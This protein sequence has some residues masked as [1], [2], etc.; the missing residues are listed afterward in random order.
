VFVVSLYHNK[1][2]LI[3]LPVAVI[4]LTVI[5]FIWA[6][7]H[8]MPPARLSITTAGVT[9]SYHSLGLRY[10][11]R[12]SAYGITLDVSASEGSQQ[13]MERLRAEQ[14]PSDLA[15]LQGGFGY[16]GTS[17]ERRERSK[18]ETLV[19]VRIEGAWLFT[20]A[21]TLTSL[22]QLKGLR[23]SAGQLG[24]GSRRVALKLLEQAQIDLKD[25]TL[26]DETGPLS[27][28]ALEQGLVDAVFFVAPDDSTTLKSLLAVPNIR[29]A[30]LSK[31]AA[32]TGRNPY[33]EPRL[34]AQGG[35][36]AGLPQQD[37]TL[38]TTTAS[39]VAREE[40]H[41]ALKRLAIAISTE[42][43]TTAGLFHRAEDFPSLR[44]LDFPS[45]PE[46]RSTLSQGLPFLE[47][48]LPFWWAQVVQ[49]LLLI[50]LP[51]LLLAWWLMRFIPLLLRWTLETRL[52]RWYGELKF[53]E[54]DLLKE[55]VP[56]LDLARF[57]VRLTAIEKELTDFRC[58][59]DLMARC[60][61]LR[62][63]TEFVRLQLY[64]VRGR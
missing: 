2:L 44:R 5:V 9:G 4:A 60:Y 32:I 42:V 54:N 43:H 27:V 47:R 31:S 26:S 58:P 6:V 57:S 62:Q 24:S 56:G 34:L 15:F 38:L 8:P 55:K 53:I 16:L 18:I 17:A 7:F 28:K 33:L 63:H 41:P 36:G 50:A 25:I 14:N 49:R 3:R 13:N 39:L 45:S 1:W 29:L 37:T 64:S 12:F 51:V 11:E 48:T 46:A 19:N 10:A 20:R 40:L 30:S 35:L 59:K 52:T 21:R 22:S 23:L 61:T